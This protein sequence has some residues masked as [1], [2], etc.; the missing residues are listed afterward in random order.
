LGVGAAVVLLPGHV[1]AA[2]ASGINV[3]VPTATLSLSGT[4]TKATGG[5]LVDANVMAVN[6]QNDVIVEH[7][8]TDSSGHWRLWDLEH[9]SFYVAIDPHAATGGTLFEQGFYDKTGTGHFTGNPSAASKVAYSGTA[10]QHIDEAVAKGHSIAG[11]IL[12][13]QPLAGLPNMAVAGDL[14]SS[15][16]LHPFN[17]VQVTTDAQGNYSIA[18]LA[19]GTYQLAVSRGILSTANVLDGCYRVAPP[20]NYTADC[21]TAASNVSVANANVTGKNVRL[22]RGHVIS[23]ILRNAQGKNLCGYI[24]VSSFATFA[25]LPTTSACGAFSIVA[26]PSGDYTM[27]VTPSTTPFV[28]G[29]YSNNA[30]H[31][32]ESG[33]TQIHVGTK[34]V[35]VGTIKPDPG[36]TFSGH[37]SLP[38]GSNFQGAVIEIISA[39]ETYNF[40]QT[41][42]NGNWTAAGIGSGTHT[43]SAGPNTYSVAT[44]NAV[45]GFYKAGAPGGYTGSASQATTLAANVDHT[46]LAM[47]LPAG[48]TISGR[49]TDASMHGISALVEASATASGGMLAFTRTDANGN[50][51][52]V[53]LATGDYIVVVTPINTATVAHDPGYYDPSAPGHFTA[54]QAQAKAVPV[55]Q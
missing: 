49:L 25:F 46:G 10:V 41:N 3:V 6:A 26:V 48:A 55:S 29:H 27:S 36:H 53:G 38:N 24:S 31:W 34:D 9:G 21:S 43:V 15:G 12:S 51:K 40:A 44:V 47:K 7:A 11:T 35:A 17:T 19:N 4:A 18:G 14:Q 22:P 1:M 28:A 20:N 52:V 42:A 37:V 30:K 13:Q 2:N 16:N 54:N 5:A 23:G 32:V 50:Y 8:N 39:T 45:G 33:G